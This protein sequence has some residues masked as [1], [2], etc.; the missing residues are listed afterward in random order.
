MEMGSVEITLSILYFSKI[1]KGNYT[2]GMHFILKYITL[3][4]PK[5]PNLLLQRK[6]SFYS[7]GIIIIC[8]NIQHYDMVILKIYYSKGSIIC[9]HSREHYRFGSENLCTCTY[10]SFRAQTLYVNHNTYIFIMFTHL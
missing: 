10:V 3:S 1:T 7:T 9:T 8:N 6:I 2:R 4:Q 5:N